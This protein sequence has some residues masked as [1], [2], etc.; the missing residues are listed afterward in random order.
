MAI[1]L[2]LLVLPHQ[3]AIEGLESKAQHAIAGSVENDDL[4]D[5]ACYMIGQAQLLQNA[6]AIVNAFWAISTLARCQSM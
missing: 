3:H 2:S 4:P 6:C 1:E 5:K